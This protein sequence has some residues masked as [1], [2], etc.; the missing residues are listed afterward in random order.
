MREEQIL[1]FTILF[2]YLS[3]TLTLPP[4]SLSLSLSLSPSCLFETKEIPT[5]SSLTLAAWSTFVS[6]SRWVD[7]VNVSVQMQIGE[8]RREWHCMVTL[9]H[10]HTLILL[11]LFYLT[12]YFSPLYV[13]QS[14]SLSPS[15]HL[16]FLTSYFSPLYLSITPP[17]LFTLNPRNQSTL[18]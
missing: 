4:L 5:T 7:Q 8:K 9:P 1:T 18:P 13:S 14:F 6:A 16:F 11:R 3:N 2:L 12:S 15:P 17:F 10:K